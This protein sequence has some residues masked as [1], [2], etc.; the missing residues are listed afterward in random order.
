AFERAWDEACK[1]S[2]SILLVPAKKKF[3]VN[4][5]VLQGPCERGF[6]FKVYRIFILY[7]DGKIVAPQSPQKWKNSNIWLQFDKLE[8]FNLVG[9]GTID[10]EGRSWWPGQCNIANTQKYCNSLDRPTAINF[11]GCNGVIIKGLSLVNS[12]KFHLTFT[13]C[14]NIQ[15]LG[16]TIKAP[17]TSPNTDGIDIFQSK[18]ILIQHNIIGTGDDCIGI[19]TGSNNIVI[20][21]VTCGPGHGISIGSLGRDNSEAEVS[22]VTVDGAKFIG[23]QNGLRIKTWQGGSGMA[24]DIT[25]EN[26]QMI[27]AGNP[28]IID[29]Y[30]CFSPNPCKNQ[31]SAVAIKNV[32]YKNVSGTSATAT[33]VK[34][35]CSK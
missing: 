9:I 2:S 26:I 33:A 6:I 14:E 31:T 19:G 21:D 25:Y 24:R 1:K 12:P 22:N 32:T 16:L 18:N 10:G 35:D 20:K 5:L 3:V 28:I 11:N 34:L 13:T 7:V 15:I 27:N 23:T 8:D 29:Q 30:Y 4:N 17:E